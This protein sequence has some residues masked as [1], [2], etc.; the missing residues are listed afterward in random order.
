MKLTVGRTSFLDALVPA[1]RIVPGSSPKPILL[2]VLISAEPERT[3]VLAT[4]LE[5]G[6]RFTVDGAQCDVAKQLCLSVRRLVAILKIATEDLVTIEVPETTEDAH[7]TVCV[8][9]SKFKLVTAVASKFPDVPA[10]DATA[11]HLIDAASLRKAIDRTVYACD[12]ASARYAL[13]GC[14]IECEAKGLN[15][16]ATDGRRMAW[17]CIAA[18]A[19]EKHMDRNSDT[20]IV[21]HA[22]LELVRQILPDAGQAK[23][24]LDANKCIVRSNGATISS[25][26]VEGRFPKWRELLPTTTKT[27]VASVVLPVAPFTQLLRQASIMTNDSDDRGVLLT[28]EI[29]K[30]AAH[31]EA[32]EVG[33]SDVELPVSYDGKPIAATF[34]PSYILDMLK[35][36]PQEETVTM[37]LLDSTS[38]AVFK[39]GDAFVYCLMP[40]TPAR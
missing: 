18:E 31:A 28:T 6:G 35:S 10:F 23:L 3:E 32:A 27:K 5:I 2:N 7:A 15:F 29:G 12:V 25:R 30:L 38:A 24:A 21:Q 33:V 20:H 26:L 36:L 16:V 14:L 13:N 19:V 9:R 1:A 4:N 8:G 40:L 11:Y 17:Q 39:T 34:M 22:A 37:D